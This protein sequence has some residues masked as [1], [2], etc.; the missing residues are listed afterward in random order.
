MAWTILFKISSPNTAMTREASLFS[1][2]EISRMRLPVIT[3][4]SMIL[5]W[6]AR[7]VHERCFGQFQEFC[8]ETIISLC[9][10]EFKILHFVEHDTLLFGVLHALP[11]HTMIYHAI[12]FEQRKKQTCRRKMP[13][14]AFNFL[15]LCLH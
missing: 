5:C 6:K 13:E 12:I 7:Q 14:I 15:L 2:F 11:S 4:K 9:F 8:Y 3:G 10:K 1:G